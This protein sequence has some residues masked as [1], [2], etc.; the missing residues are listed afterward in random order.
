MTFR[1]KSWTTTGELH[2]QAAGGVNRSSHLHANVFGIFHELKIVTTKNHG[3]GN[4]SFEHGELVSDALARAGAE[5]NKREIRRDFVRVQPSHEVWVVTRPV[6]HARISIRALE[7]EGIERV[8]IF[9]ALG[10]PMQVPDADENIHTLDERD[11]DVPRTLGKL[12]VFETATNKNRRFRVQAQSFS[13]AQTHG[14]KFLDIFV[15]RGAVVVAK[16]FVDIRLHALQQFWL[17]HQAV[18][19]PREH[20]RGGFMPSDKHGH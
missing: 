15:R 1:G 2:R 16:D 10:R 9:P 20:R 17:L 11:F 6:F 4:R 8:G 14:L 7:T 5:W 13:D 12:D 3:H 19:S 18:Q